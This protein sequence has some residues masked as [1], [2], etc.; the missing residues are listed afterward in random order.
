MGFSWSRY[1]TLKN[2]WME[3][4]RTHPRSLSASNRLLK[5]RP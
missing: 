3:F 2:R 5:L 1:T 4:L